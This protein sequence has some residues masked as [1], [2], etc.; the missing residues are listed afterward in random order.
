LGKLAGKVA[1][2]TG[3]SSGIG[4]ST[5]EHFIAEGAFVYIIGRR[6]KELDASIASLGENATGV[7]GDVSNLLDI[8][9]LYSQIENDEKQI[10]NHFANAGIGNQHSLL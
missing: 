8:D 2:I 1:V 5:A 10:D 3:G 6:K 9:R 4:L 7:Q